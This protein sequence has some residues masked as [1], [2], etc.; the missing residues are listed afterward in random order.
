ML[1]VYAFT[2][3]CLIVSESEETE[4]FGDLGKLLLGGFAAA[5]IVALAF[6]YIRLRL[7]ETRPETSGFI[8][9]NSSRENSTSVE[10]RLHSA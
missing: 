8:S 7:R 3:Y 1:P 9:I 2:F 6:T 10:K 5:V 4:S